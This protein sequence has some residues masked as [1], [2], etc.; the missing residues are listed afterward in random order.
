M[1]FWSFKVAASLIVPEG[2]PLEHSGLSLF[3]L[4][5]EEN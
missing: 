3:K 2:R 5:Q 1:L 4:L